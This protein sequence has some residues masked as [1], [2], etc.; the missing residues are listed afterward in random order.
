M[1]PTTARI[2]Q[3]IIYQVQSLNAV[4]RPPAFSV[5]FNRILAAAFCFGDPLAKAASVGTQILKI[6]Y[7]G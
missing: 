4:V 6:Y 7:V 2:R 3:T 5:A 1:L